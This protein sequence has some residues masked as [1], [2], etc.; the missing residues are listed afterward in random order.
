MSAR[1]FAVFATVAMGT[2]IAGNAAR[3]QEPAATIRLR[4]LA[5]QQAIATAAVRQP[6][7][8]NVT[9]REVVDPLDPVERFLL[10][11][12]GGPLIVEVSMTIDGQPFHALREKI[13]DD[14]L[15]AADTDK[16]GH[17]T[18]NEALKNLRFHGGRYRGLT[19][20]Q[21]NQTRPT[22]D[23]NGN[24]LVDRAEVRRFIAQN[25]QGSDFVLA[26]G[27]SSDGTMRAVGQFQ[28][29]NIQVDLKKFLDTDGDGKL[30]VDEIAAAPQRLKSRDAD[31]ND[32]L[33]PNEM[34]GALPDQNSASIQQM[35]RRDEALTGNQNAILLGPTTTAEAIFGVLIQKYHRGEDHLPA[36][37]FPN[38][39][40]LFE[41]LDENHNGLLE[42]HELLTLNTLK[43]HISLAVNVGQR[44]DAPPLAMAALADELGKAETPSNTAIGLTRSDYRLAF[45]TNPTPPFTPNFEAAATQMLQQ[46]DTDKKGYLEPKKLSGALATQLELWDTDSDGKVFHKEIV[47]AYT[48]STAPQQS[49]IRATVDVQSNAVFQMLDQSGDGRLS[50]REM[51]TAA[52]RLKLFDKNTSGDVTSDEIPPTFAVTFSQ[53][54]SQFNANRVLAF[55]AGGMVRPATPPARG[56]AWF[57]RMDRNGDGDV[58]LKE[59]LGDEEQFQRL[60]TNADGF[61]EP[62]EAEAAAAP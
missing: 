5:S 17:A 25:L 8:N 10:L 49:Q 59:F 58:T 26:T 4:Q 2:L 24:G 35:R 56:P 55:G 15:A 34:A 11:A 12:P 46:Y 31:D 57:T 16:D 61:I 40:A 6:F 18:W 44:G 21:I 23:T 38:L 20:E 30:S 27:G 39:P 51:R 14:L 33:I 13:V 53:G 3:S 62:K 37:C 60:D 45:A 54:T 19:A 32:L 9:V 28:N 47:E 43:P 42:V 48:R 41:Q 29:A 36:K 50:L 1:R 22:L 52:E 7:N